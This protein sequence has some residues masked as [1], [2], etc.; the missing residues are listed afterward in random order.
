MNSL[1]AQAWPGEALR[2]TASLLGWGKIVS[3]AP[4]T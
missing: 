2:P 1:G 4:I 3:K